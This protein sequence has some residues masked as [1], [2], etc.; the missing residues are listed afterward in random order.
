[1]PRP[2]AGL[3]C[4]RRP[5]GE[6]TGALYILASALAFSLMSVCVK[7][8]AQRIPTQEIVFIRALF[9]LVVSYAM[10]RAASIPVWG[11]R[12]RMLLLRGALGYAALSCVFY[13][14]A[15]LPLAEATIIQ[16]AHPFFT[17]LLA[18]IFLKE[19][20]PR[21]LLFAMLL[22]LAGVA[23]VTRPSAIWGATASLPTVPVLVALLGAVLTAAAYVVVR[24]LSRTED[25]LVIVFYFPFVALP[26]SLPAMLPNAVWPTA[27]EWLALG[28]VGV[29]AQL[30]QV[31]LT[32]GLA[33]ETAARGTALSYLYVVFATAWGVLFFAETPT[34]WTMGGA[35]LVVLGSV[36]A[37]RTRD[38]SP[39]AG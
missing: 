15:H 36:A 20:A 33:L 8:A 13:A 17:A 16:Y 37:A 2:A 23:L 6:L 22:S 32:R 39:V 11:K 18:S 34:R 14:V 1:V 4:G 38:R 5:S 31:Y 29:F 30:G 25:A 10:L 27:C 12:P 21:S 19:N 26:A 3:I 24:S 35:A 7:L 28:G 9:T